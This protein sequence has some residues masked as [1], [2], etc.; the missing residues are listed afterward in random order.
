MTMMTDDTYVC[1]RLCADFVEAL[2]DPISFMKQQLREL[3]DDLPEEELNLAK[4]NPTAKVQAFYDCIIHTL[5]KAVSLKL[6]CAV[7]YF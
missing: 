5:A 6:W 2:I 4:H 7:D 1:L 3:L